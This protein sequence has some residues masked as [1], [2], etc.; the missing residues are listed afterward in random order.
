MNNGLSHAYLGRKAIVISKHF[1]SA[2][3][4]INKRLERVV[5]HIALMKELCS[6]EVMTSVVSVGHSQSSS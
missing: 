3:S 4:L 2:I 1:I 5:L 6:K